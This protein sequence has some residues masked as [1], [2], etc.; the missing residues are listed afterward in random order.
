[1]A[2]RPI[3]F[4]AASSRGKALSLADFEGKVP[5]ALVFLG[6]LDPSGG[7]IADLDRHHAEFGRQRVQLLA[8]DLPTEPAHHGRP[9]RWW[10]RDSRRRPLMLPAMLRPNRN[11]SWNAVATAAVSSRPRPA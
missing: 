10:T 1:M 7:D 2:T 6:E 3:D 4:H 9:G 8:H 5:I 11:G